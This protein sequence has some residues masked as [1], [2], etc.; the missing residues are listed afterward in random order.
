[1]KILAPSIL[2]PRL[3]R[4]P[5]KAGLAASHYIKYSYTCLKFQNIGIWGR[6]ALKVLTGVQ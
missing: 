4:G 2:N 6:A 5:P 1:M 3:A